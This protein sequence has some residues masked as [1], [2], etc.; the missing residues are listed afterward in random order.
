MVFHVK[1]IFDDFG[2]DIILS[3]DLIWR[4]TKI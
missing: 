2:L 1:L 3:F 4:Y